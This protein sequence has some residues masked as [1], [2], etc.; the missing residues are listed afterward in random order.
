MIIQAI[1]FYVF[2]AVTV[3]AAVMVVTAARVGGTAGS[4]EHFV[5]V[6][7]QG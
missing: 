3:A 6:H 4:G 2:A 7:E 5:V 1:S